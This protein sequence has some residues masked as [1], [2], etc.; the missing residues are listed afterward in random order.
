MDI[1]NPI[2]IDH[3][4]EIDGQTIRPEELDNTE[5]AALTAKTTGIGWKRD[6]DG[7]YVLP[8]G[9]VDVA[10]DVWRFKLVSMGSWNMDADASKNVAHGLSPLANIFIVANWVMNDALNNTDP[11]PCY[12]LGGYHV[13]G[14][15]LS[16]N[17]IELRREPDGY[18]DNAAY[19][20]TG[21]DRGYVLLMYKL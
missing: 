9:I 12:V 1:S 17:Y 20:D 19:N 14:I 7:E 11:L 21:F 8:A 16:T 10:G 18:F 2:N 5:F 13:P 6:S 4:K 3:I 15:S